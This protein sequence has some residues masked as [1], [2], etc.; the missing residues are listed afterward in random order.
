LRDFEDDADCDAA[1]LCVVQRIENARV[2]QRIGRKVDGL[3]TPSVPGELNVV[4][5]TTFDQFG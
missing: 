4:N 3:L 5:W 1:A 2:R